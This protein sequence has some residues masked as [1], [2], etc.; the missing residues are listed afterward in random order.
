MCWALYSCQ[1]QS[2]SSVMDMPKHRHLA[3]TT[4]RCAYVRETHSKPIR[5]AVCLEEIWITGLYINKPEWH[6][7]HKRRVC[8]QRAHIITTEGIYTYSNSLWLLQIQVYSVGQSHENISTSNCT[9][10]SK[11]KRSLKI[12]FDK[13]V[14]LESLRLQTVLLHYIYSIYKTLWPPI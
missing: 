11:P 6:H 3:A 10:K 9:P 8:P 12:Y 7:E 2:T 14:F 1:P 4:N 13:N 5:G